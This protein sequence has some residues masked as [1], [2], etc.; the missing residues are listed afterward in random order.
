LLTESER[1]YVTR[2]GSADVYSW[3]DIFQTSKANYFKA[4]GKRAT[5]SVQSNLPNAY[6]LHHMHGNTWD[7]VEDCFHDSYVGAPADG[8]AWIEACS[9]EE[10]VVRGGSWSDVPRVLRS[11]H[12][13]KNIPIFRVSF[14]GFRVAKSW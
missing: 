11:A 10:K 5:V 9:L 2:A 13:S 8:S 1:E 12:R 7:W 14:V 4:D 6:G 3:G